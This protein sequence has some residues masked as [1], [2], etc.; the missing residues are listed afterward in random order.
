[1]TE[2]SLPPGL[3]RD[4]LAVRTASERSQYGENSEALY[5]T[6]GFVQPDAETSA[7]RFA[8]TEEGFTY[9]RTSNPTVASFEQRLAA[10]EGTEAAIAASSGMGAILMMCMGLLKAGD[11]VICSRSV[12][13]STLNLFGKEFAKFGIETTF[14]SQTDVAEWRAALRPTT[15]LLFAETPTNPLTEVCDIR[16]LADLAHDA[17][18]LLAVDNCFCSPALQRP[19][20]LGADLVIHS[21][22]KYL[23]GQGR[24]MAGAIC[25]PS[26]LIVDVFGPVVRTAGMVLAPFNAWVVLK[27]METLGIRM[28]AQSANALAV[29][30]W[31]EGHPK[32]SR[33]HYPGLAS[34][35]QHELAMRQQSGQ[36]GAVVSF[37]VRGDDPATARKNAFHVIDSTRV[38]S[39]ATNLGDTKTIITHPGTTSHGRLTEAQRQAAGIGQGLIR[40]AVGLDHIDDIQADLLRG[41]DTLSS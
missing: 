36:G 24:V 34:H 21:G 18:A 12:F 6:S 8:G 28:Q 16:A 15:K 11:H 23:D 7:R 9:S 17:G 4:T 1:M 2:R 5:L 29:A 14:V 30:Q 38:V 32:V 33:V 37:D 39:I 19:T 31:L 3:H 10:L 40:L 22:T 27:G 20:E 35:P 41:L 25:G 13:G 26:R